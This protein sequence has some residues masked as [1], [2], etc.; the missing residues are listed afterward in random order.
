MHGQAAFAFSQKYPYVFAGIYTNSQEVHMFNAEDLSNVTN[1]QISNGEGWA[2]GDLYFTNNDELLVL[3]QDFY[4]DYTKS[5][6][7]TLTDSPN[8]TLMNRYLFAGTHNITISMDN[9]YMVYKNG[10]YSLNIATGVLT[11]TLLKSDL[12]TILSN[13]EAQTKSGY[14]HASFDN[15]GKV[16]YIWQY[17]S[18]AY[19]YIIDYDNLEANLYKTLHSNTIANNMLVASVGPDRKCIFSSGY[20]VD[21]IYEQT[22]TSFARRGIKYVNTSD[23]TV[24]AENIIKDEVAYG[25]DGKLTG[26][27][28]NNGALTYTPSTEKQTIPAGYTS[29]GTI[30]A[31]PVTEEEY[32]TCLELTNQIIGKEYKE[33]NN[34][35][36]IQ[37]NG[38]QWLDT[39]YTP[40][41]NT[42]IIIELSDIVKPN[43]TAIFGA[44]TTWKEN[45]YLLYC[46]NSRKMNWTYNGPITITS[47]LTSKHTITIFRGTVILDG[48]TV[49]TNTQ[50]NSSAVNSTLTLFSIPG[51]QYRGSYKLYSF[52][53]YE[54][55]VLIKNYIPVK[56]VLNIVC[57]Y[58]TINKQYIYNQGPNEFISGE[59]V[60]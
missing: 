51:G 3:T 48:S 43:E 21:V 57:L 52:K 1:T 50:I 41:D 28:P 54:N 13:D 23:A 37:A 42:K 27:M 19:I 56:D 4:W 20:S 17:S 30:A 10:L 44:N 25:K 60:K 55:D 2:L 38:T 22:L 31:Y 46:L 53:I 5:A 35:A 9:Q 32:N 58:D 36:Y 18:G 47:D 45:S 40:N 34:L 8:H 6:I 16:L 12:T 59:E 26:T 33:Y 39:G 29:G 11:T 7:F 24:T 49:S 15:S 14:I